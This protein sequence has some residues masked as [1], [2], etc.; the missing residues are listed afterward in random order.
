MQ[1]LERNKQTFHYSLCLGQTD[2]VDA[3]GF[4][5]GE[6]KVTYAPPVEMRA[7]ISASRGTVDLDQFGLN[8]AYS[9][10]ITIAG[11][12]PI[13]IG[14]ILWIGFGNWVQADWETTPHNYVVTAVAESLNSTTIAIKEVNVS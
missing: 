7:N 6:H 4:L 11:K 9:K 1:T 10:T 13:T 2:V 3:N 12:T 14:T 8:A 5:T